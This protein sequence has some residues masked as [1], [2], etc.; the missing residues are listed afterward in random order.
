VSIL[1][2]GE[3]RVCVMGI[4]GRIGRVQTRYM[5][6]AGTRIVSGVTP[7]KGGQQV[8]GVPVFHTVAAAQ[9]ESPADAALLFVPP[10]AAEE[11]GTEAIAAGFPLV[12]LVTE[13]VPVHAAMRLRSR[14][15]TTGVR[16]LG[17]TTPGIIAPGRCK[18]G[19]MP[20]SL[21]GRGPVGVVS[22]SG[23][24]SYEIGGALA[25]AGL[26]QSTVVGMGA[27]PVVGTDLTE[28]LDLFEADPETETVVVIG[29]VGGD[30]EERAAR[31]LAGR[32]HKPVVAYIAG[33]SVPTGV[34]MGH[35]GAIVQGEAGSAAGKAEAFAAAGVPTA[36]G[37]AEVVDL[38]RRAIAQRQGRT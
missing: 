28:L 35:A 36:T 25:A 1:I 10:A 4:T 30:Q 22:R 5:Q 20:A 23:T 24:L 27:D 3:T 12:V 18:I 19:I 2:D 6:E 15:R 11:A 21:F 37:P 8:E 31:N 17:P 9:A 26:G 7:G 32:G 14:A 16:L 38:I 29:E 13:G 33:R 34:R